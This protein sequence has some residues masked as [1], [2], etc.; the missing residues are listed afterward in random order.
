VWGA[1]GAA[2]ITAGADIAI[3]PKAAMV[4]DRLMNCRR[5]RGKFMESLKAEWQEIDI[6]EAMPHLISLL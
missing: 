6:N 2:A 5:L 3:I 1:S 4:V